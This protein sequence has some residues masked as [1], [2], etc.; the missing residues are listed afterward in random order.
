MQ[1]CGAKRRASRLVRARSCRRSK[2]WKVRA[3][4]W[5]ALLEQYGD[6]VVQE[7][8]ASVRSPAGMSADELA[9]LPHDRRTRVG[10]CYRAWGIHFGGGDLIRTPD[11]RAHSCLRMLRNPCAGTRS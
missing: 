11:P 1:S 9:A 5:R 2:A 6:L 7:Y 4:A 10:A 8:I 3:S